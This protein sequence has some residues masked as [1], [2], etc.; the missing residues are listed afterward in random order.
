MRRILIALFVFVLASSAVLAVGAE[1]EHGEGGTNLFAGDVG[2]AFW[3]LI[4]FVL[5]V[6]VLGKFAWGPLLGALQQREQFIRDAL[7]DAKRDREAAEARLAEYTEKLHEARAEASKIVDEGRRDAAVVKGRIEG[8]ARE[9]AERTI[10][11]AKRE[12]ELAKN[13]AIKELYGKTAEMATEIATRVVRR[14]ISAA[15]H[16]KLISEAID[17]L[18][19]QELH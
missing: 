18:A 6:V 14:E 16:Q 17:S 15:D 7:A 3:T 13:A 11:R 12:I 10:E 19:D 9:E 4:I 1:G 5:V 8:E 2:N